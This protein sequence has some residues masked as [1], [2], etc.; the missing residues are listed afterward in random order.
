MNRHFVVALDRGHLR[1]FAETRPLGQPPRLE[2]VEAMDF[3][4]EKRRSQEPTGSI[5]PGDRTGSVEVLASELDSFLLERP[6]AS[7]DFAAPAKLYHAVSSRLSEDTRRRLRRTLSKNL[8]NEKGD[9]VEE[10]F[11]AEDEWQIATGW[12]GIPESDRSGL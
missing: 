2:I 5:A 11:G 10:P 1:I 4:L 6:D 3:P 9:D 8:V 7:W 12:S